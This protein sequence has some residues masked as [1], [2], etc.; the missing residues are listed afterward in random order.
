MKKLK[1]TPV[2]TTETCGGNGYEIDWYRERSFKVKADELDSVA[3]M[4]LRGLELPGYQC[5][6]VLFHKKKGRVVWQSCP[7]T[8]MDRTRA[9]W[10]FANFNCHDFP[11][12]DAA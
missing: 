10:A 12:E 7:L 5:K 11:E 2:F 6:L 3:A 9:L 4:M 8:A 1:I